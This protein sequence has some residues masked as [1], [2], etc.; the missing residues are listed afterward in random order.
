MLCLSMAKDDWKNA[1]SESQRADF[2][3][4]AQTFKEYGVTQS[5]IEVTEQQKQ[6]LEDFKT[7]QKAL[8]SQQ[9]SQQSYDYQN[10]SGAEVRAETEQVNSK[11]GIN[12]QYQTNVNHQNAQQVEKQQAEN[13]SKATQLDNREAELA[14]KEQE[15]ELDRDDD[16]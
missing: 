12:S 7:N 9:V 3:Q 11:L 1:L 6:T 10:L 2:E 4:A 16:R 5:P 15:Q 14:E 13:D 8:D